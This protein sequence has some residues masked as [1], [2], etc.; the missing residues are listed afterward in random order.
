MF[1]WK[2]VSA[3]TTT[4][5]VMNGMNP[6]VLRLLVSVRIFGNDDRTSLPRNCAA[7]VWCLPPFVL[8]FYR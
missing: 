7:S 6:E 5:Y 4:A 2:L 8:I 1:D 3:N